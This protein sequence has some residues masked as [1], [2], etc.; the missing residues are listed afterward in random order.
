MEAGF[1]HA[2]CSTLVSPSP[3][4][5][6]DRLLLRPLDH[7]DAHAMHRVYSDP[8]VMRY[9]PGGARDV[10]GSAARLQELID[11]QQKHG[12]SKW[13]VVTSDGGEVI[14]DCGF[15]YLEGGPAI[16]LGFHIARTH[17]RHGYATEAA[18]AW[19][20]WARAHRREPAVAIVNPDNSPSIRV[21][22][23]SGMRYTRTGTYFDRVWDIWTP[24]DASRAADTARSPEPTRIT[25][26]ESNDR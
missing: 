17:W 5:E 26:G 8:C 20:A 2:Y 19:L 16:E 7:P 13:A 12:F 4:I 23:K 10:P 9:I 3:R 15:Q 6:T 25:P 24:A 21:L 22:E 11:H 1:N 18:K 14:G